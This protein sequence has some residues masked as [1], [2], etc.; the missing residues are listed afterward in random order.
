MNKN[1]E[2]KN[3]RIIIQIDIKRFIDS[4]D[5]EEEKDIL[6][7]I[8]LDEEVSNIADRLNVPKRDIKRILIKLLRELRTFRK[9]NNP[10]YSNKENTKKR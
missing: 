1:E 9:E 3:D 5:T 2:D 8:L 4:L 6:K 10:I 7:S